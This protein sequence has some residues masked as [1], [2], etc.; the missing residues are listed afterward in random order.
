MTF[1]PVQLDELDK[2]DKDFWKKLE[3]SKY[4][5]EFIFP[6]I[7]TFTYKIIVSFAQKPNVHFIRILGKMNSFSFF[8]YHL[9]HLN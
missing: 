8:E 2:L 9:M 5:R 3:Y 7:L 1:L 6:R 4:Y